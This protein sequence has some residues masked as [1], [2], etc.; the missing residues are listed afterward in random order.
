MD[1]SPRGLINIPNGQRIS[2]VPSTTHRTICLRA[3]LHFDD[4][5]TPKYHP[6][7]LSGGDRKALKKELMKSGA[8]DGN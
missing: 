7:P 3:A 4:A 6:T 5:M 8:I 2:F 1:R